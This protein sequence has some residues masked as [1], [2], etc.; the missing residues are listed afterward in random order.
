MSRNTCPIGHKKL[1]ESIQTAQTAATAATA[2]AA[3][4]AATTAASVAPPTPDPEQLL[5][6]DNTDGCGGEVIMA[7]GLVGSIHKD[8]SGPY[9]HGSFVADTAKTEESTQHSPAGRHD[10]KLKDFC[11]VSVVV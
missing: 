7:K 4:A 11:Q 2:T 9:C 5:H 10:Q 8:Y 1:I 6:A 3:A